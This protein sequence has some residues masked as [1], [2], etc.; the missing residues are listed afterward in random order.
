MSV[1]LKDE[2]ATQAGAQRLIYPTE[3]LYAA[4]RRPAR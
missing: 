1:P 2:S 4:A 3:N